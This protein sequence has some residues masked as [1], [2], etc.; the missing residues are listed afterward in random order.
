MTEQDNKK[1]TAGMADNTKTKQVKTVKPSTKKKTTATKKTATA[2]KS[3]K[4]TGRKAT[5]KTTSIKVAKP[6]TEAVEKPKKAESLFREIEEQKPETTASEPEKLRE[7]IHET[8]ETVEKA[9]REIREVAERAERELREKQQ[10]TAVI[11]NTDV[12][13][14]PETAEKSEPEI[15]VTEERHEEP[16]FTGEPETEQTPQSEPETEIPPMESE[17]PESAETQPEEEKQTDVTGEEMQPTEEK[18]E[19]PAPVTDPKEEKENLKKAKRE[20]KKAA[21]ARRAEEKAAASRKQEKKK[22]N[23]KPEKLGF[24]WFFW[25]SFLVLM[26]PVSYFGWLLFQASQETN[27]PVIGDRIKNDIEVEIQQSSLSNIK[28]Q[29]LNL[30]GVEKCEVNLIVETLRI[31]ADVTDNM[32]EEKVQAMNKA[33]YDIVDAEIP[34]EDYFTARFSY[35]EYDLEITSYTSLDQEAPAIAILTKNSMMETYEN[36]IV[37]KPKNAK[38]A[39]ELFVLAEEQKNDEAIAEQ[40]ANE[41][42]D[43]DWSTVS[44]AAKK[45][46]TKK[47]D[48]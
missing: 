38:I 24:N 22:K 25:I 33:I 7:V 30:E 18:A 6:K 40:R 12:T 41:S 27:T 11:E 8:A 37:S 4:T 9:E 35:K 20:A 32:T 48:E 2:K 29:I 1:T 26:V 45:F 21:A 10:E 17:K 23:G 14:T 3:T 34:V 28:T 19:T 47:T 42:H 44:D 13:E 39:E 36:R 46:V 15:P 31:S 16:V 43:A 5:G